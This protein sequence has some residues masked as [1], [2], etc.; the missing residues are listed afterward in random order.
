MNLPARPAAR[1]VPCSAKTG[2]RPRS[3]TFN[4]LHATTGDFAVD[5]IRVFHEPLAEAGATPC[6]ACFR[7]PY[8]FRAFIGAV[9]LKPGTASAHPQQDQDFRAFIGAVSLKPDTGSPCPPHSGGFPRLHRRGLI[10]ANHAQPS[11]RY[12]LPF[13]RLHRRGLIEASV[14]SGQTISATVNFRAF[15]G[16]VSLKRVGVGV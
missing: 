9:S 11:S 5:M 12:I 13:P 14:A 8:H 2:S 7:R 16:A 4:I 1:V 10:E 6:S 3:L 15:I